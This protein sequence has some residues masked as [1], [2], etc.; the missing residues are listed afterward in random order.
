M[1]L[2]F[3]LTGTG[4]ATRKDMPNLFIKHCKKEKTRITS[5]L[6]RMTVHWY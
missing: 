2:G 5:R 4:M 1:A 6:T 3:T